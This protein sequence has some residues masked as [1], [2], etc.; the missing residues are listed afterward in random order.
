M[1]IFRFSSR[2]IR[3][4]MHLLPLPYG[5]VK[6]SGCCSRGA[7]FAFRC[8]FYRFLTVA[9]P[10]SSRSTRLSMHLLP[11]PHGRGSVSSIKH[12]RSRDR[13]GAVNGAGDASGF[14]RRDRGSA[15]LAV[16]WLSA[17][18][19]AIA[20]SLSTTV[21]SETD[22]ASTAID[23][24]RCYY[25]ATGAVERA[26][27]EMFWGMDRPDP[28]I[29]HD[30]TSVD[31]QF[32]LGTAHVEILPEAGKLNVNQAP[33]E[34]LYKLLAALGAD[35]ERAQELALAIDDW[36]KPSAAATSLDSYYLSQI[37][38][39]RQPHA[40]VQELEELL[41]VK[42]MT[43]E[44]FYGTYVPSPEGSQGPRLLPQPGLA[45]CLTVYGP[46][47]RIDVNTAPLPVLV[48]VGVPPEVARALVARRRV[49]PFD[50]SGLA[51]FLEGAGANMGL[52]RV[53]GNSIVTLR[54]TARLRLPNGQLGDLKRTVAEQVKFMPYGY[55]SPLHI[56]RWYDTAWS[57]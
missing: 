46:D 9:A 27:L 33:V 40:S 43:P 5:S 53:G 23:G 31:Y 57:N 36:R 18:L 32:P 38:S 42:G 4:S 15:L 52:L 55:D 6:K 11:L 39:F 17:A 37:P 13:K 49:T 56:L 28:P 26:Q 16:L 20:F 7:L 21:R 25:L 51:K 10:F 34:M 12:V 48:A 47:N 19:A 29:P 22:R 14:R 44:L 1:A 50:Y 41:R 45:D 35:P 54:A 24:V 8:A 2:F 30:A 3:F